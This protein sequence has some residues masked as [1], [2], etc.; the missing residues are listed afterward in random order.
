MQQA[1]SSMHKD[2]K[3]TCSCVYF[4]PIR[5]CLCLCV[6]VPQ[7]YTQLTVILDDPDFPRLTLSVSQLSHS[8]ISL[9][10]LSLYLSH[11]KS[12]Q[13]METHLCIP[14]MRRKE[15]N[16]NAY[17]PI[18][19]MHCFSFVWYHEAWKAKEEVDCSSEAR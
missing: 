16:V 6:C 3:E 9:F 8:I 4:Y 19:H 5:V 2:T 13:K 18:C 14:Y 12:G 15:R 7:L 17:L 11:T 10:S 1:G